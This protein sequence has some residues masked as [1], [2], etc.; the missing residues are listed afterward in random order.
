M[1]REAPS[2]VV[3]EHAASRSARD[4]MLMQSSPGCGRA[5]SFKA[6]DGDDATRPRDLDHRREYALR[7][8]RMINSVKAPG[9]IEIFGLEVRA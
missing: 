5:F 3:Q 1:T 2:C 8:F 6:L 4:V 9:K 7:I